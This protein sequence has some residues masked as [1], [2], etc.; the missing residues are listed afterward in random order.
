MRLSAWIAT[1]VMALAG[2]DPTLARQPPHEISAGA[3]AGPPSDWDLIDEG[4]DVT[5]YAA[6]NETPS[7]VIRCKRGAFDVLLLDLPPATS[8]SGTRILEVGFDGETPVRT[9]WSIADPSTRA[10]ATVPAYLARRLRR[11]GMFHLI[12]PADGEAPR[13]EY[14]LP[15]PASEHAID[16]AL[17]A[18]DLPLEDPRDPLIER[19][20][21]APEF[22]PQ[23][24]RLPQAQFPNQAAQRGVKSGQAHMSCFVQPDGRLRDC[25]VENERPHGA[26]FGASVLQALR[27]ARLD[28][29]PDDP[30]HMVFFTVRFRIR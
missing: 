21:L 30:D 10:L 12:V 4:R 25:R 2:S 22:L 14:R 23:W 28:K 19:S 29:A 15:L 24:S 17:T 16:A 6:F 9:G 27:V 18:C 7:F 26:G 3:I 5:A 13:Q 11:G 1:F 20:W 8:E